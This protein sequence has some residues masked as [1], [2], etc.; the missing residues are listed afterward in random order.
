MRK[1]PNKNILKKSQV[2]AH[3]GEDVKQWEPSSIAGGSLNLYNHFGNHFG[4][5]SNIWE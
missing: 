4:G 2:L 1:I 3:D 5:F